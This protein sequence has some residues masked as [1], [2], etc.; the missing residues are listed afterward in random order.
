MTYERHRYAVAY[1][2]VVVTIIL[3]L[4]VLLVVTDR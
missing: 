1:I 3:A 4:Q 2:A